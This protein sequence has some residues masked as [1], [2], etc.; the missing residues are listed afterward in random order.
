MI[1]IDLTS[2]FI[3]VKCSTRYLTTV[4]QS[5]WGDIKILGHCSV[6]VC[7]HVC[8]CVQSG[9]I[10]TPWPMGRHE[11]GGKVGGGGEAGVHACAD[12][13]SAPAGLREIIQYLSMKHI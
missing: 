13:Q 6:S 1:T 3:Q 7:L 2:I 8:P 9:T 4:G 12:G 5:P 10:S 11:D